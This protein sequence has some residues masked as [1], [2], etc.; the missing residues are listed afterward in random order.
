MFNTREL[1]I[2]ECTRERVLYNCTVIYI[3]IRDIVCMVNIYMYVT[4][5]LTLIC[6]M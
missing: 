3:N 4:C 2:T 1:N 5:F 6:K